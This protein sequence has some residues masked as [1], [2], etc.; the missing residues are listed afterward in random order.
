[1]KEQDGCQDQCTSTARKSRKKNKAYAAATRNAQE[2]EEGSEKKGHGTELRKSILEILSM[3][4][5]GKTC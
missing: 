5:A 3:R 4:A 2:G 1:M